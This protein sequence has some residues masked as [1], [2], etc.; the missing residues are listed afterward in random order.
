MAPKISVLMGIYNCAD[1]L[2]EAIESILNQ[3]EQDF[4]LILCN[5]GST[6]GTLAVAEDY[7][8]RYPDKIVLLKNEKNLG[9][10]KTLNRCLQ[11]AR[12]EYIA[13]MDGD[14][15][16]DPTR[17]EKQLAVLESR[18]DIVLL[19]WT[20]RLFDETG[21]WGIR[22][23]PAQPKREDFSWGNPFN[24]GSCMGRKAAFDAMGGYS[25][26]PR[27][28][29][30]EDFHL[31][32]RMYAAGMKGMNLPEPLYDLRSDLTAAGRRR[33]K[34]R[35]NEAYVTGFGIHRLKLPLWRYLLVLRPVLLGLLPRA[36]YLKLHKKKLGLL[37]NPEA[38]GDGEEKRA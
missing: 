1:T 8:T 21:V 17:F 13:R 36:L 28:V 10:N 5:D 24:H 27:T 20:I 18:E 7:Q 26:D 33:L 37:A 15:R 29:R 25:E 11:A 23:M 12:G 31:W 3:T 2:P 6:D 9:L 30:V 34:A 19:G 14:D 38:Q 22:R 4:E 32:I 35:L 16:C